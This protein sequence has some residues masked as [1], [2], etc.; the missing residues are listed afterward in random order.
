MTVLLFHF[1]VMCTII[2]SACSDLSSPISDTA[3]V[4]TNALV[5]ITSPVT[6]SNINKEIYGTRAVILQPFVESVSIDEFPKPKPLSD[7]IT[8]PEPLAAPEIHSE[9]PT[10]CL[11]TT[12]HTLTWSEI[13]VHDSCPWGFFN[14]EKYK[15]MMFVVRTRCTIAAIP[16]N[17]AITARGY[18]MMFS[19]VKWPVAVAMLLTPVWKPL[20][21]GAMERIGC[22][23]FQIRCSTA[24][25]AK[26]TV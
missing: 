21:V 6:K 2:L 25:A 13:F 26:H 1:L 10:R 23:I 16:V 8:R 12:Y 11:N 3:S 15:R 19:T 18:F 17:A 9:I 14:N 24:G 22:R 5:F 7:G 4:S 20:V